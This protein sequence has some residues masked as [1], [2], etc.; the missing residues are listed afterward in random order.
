M[1]PRANMSDTRNPLVQERMPNFNPENPEVSRDSPMATVTFWEVVFETYFGAAMKQPPPVFSRVNIQNSKT[2]KQPTKSKGRET[3]AW[4]LHKATMLCQ[5][6]RKE[7][8]V[9][10][11]WGRTR[12]R[13]GKTSPDQFSITSESNTVPSSQ[14]YD[15][16]NPRT[17]TERT[18]W[19]IISQ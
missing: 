7:I 10:I 13:V 2:Y 1:S 3:Y 6:L 8:N 11:S 14:T 4:A 12:Y 16:Q 15:S 17:P 5:I 18:F 9:R 19:H